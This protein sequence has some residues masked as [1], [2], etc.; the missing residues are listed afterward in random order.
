MEISL[1]LLV[2]TT[3]NVESQEDYEQ[4]RDKL[5]TELENQGFSISIESEESDDEDFNFDLHD[6]DYESD[7]YDDFDEEEDLDDY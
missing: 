5:M 2:Q 1:T 4:Q 3:L 7:E 6:E